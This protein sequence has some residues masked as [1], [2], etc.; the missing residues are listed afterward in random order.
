MNHLVIDPDSKIP[1]LAL[2]KISAWAKQKGDHVDLRHPTRVPDEVWISCIFTWNKEQALGIGSFYEQ[3][4]KV[5]YGGTAFDWGKGNGL[6]F[7]ERINLPPEI[8]FTEPDY[9]LY[10]DDR[11][12]NFSI[13]GCDRTCSFCDVWRKEGKINPKLYQS[14][15]KWVPDWMNKVADL[16]N[17]ISLPSVPK[18]MHND[19]I[20]S[21]ASSGRKL[22]IT[23]GY[24]IRCVTEEK[25]QIL[26]E[27]KPWSIH[28]DEHRLYT[29]WDLMSSEKAV[30]HNL[31]LLLD[32]G[33]KGREIF[34]FLICGDPTIHAKNHKGFPL[35]G[36]ALCFQELKYRHDIVWKQYG[37]YPFTMVFNKRRD[38]PRL[39][40]FQRWTNKPALHKTCEWEEYWGN[41]D[42]YEEKDSDQGTIEP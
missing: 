12:V 36:C 30:H 41:P 29:A 24:D 33:F 2:M 20:L 5:H 18:W 39:S 21:C 38:D 11:A 23:Q 37:C 27:N 15:S 19:I 34:F 8:E 40:A 31:P 7:S 25:A 13:R 26:A 42:R 35:T 4:A 10:D 1:N 28:F 17:D 16:S 9:R 14:P 22:S 32:A 3:S 6:D